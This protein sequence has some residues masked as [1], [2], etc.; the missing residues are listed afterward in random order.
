MA[1]FQT[2]TRDEVNYSDYFGR[3]VEERLFSRITPSPRGINLF[4]LNDGTFT[5]IEPAFGEYVFVYY[6][7]HV[8]DVTP[9]EQADL[10]A[11]GY[12]DYIEA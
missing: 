6:G 9:Q 7:G 11:A 12:G 4:K 10:I 2:P 1:T 5:E 3:N 8:Y